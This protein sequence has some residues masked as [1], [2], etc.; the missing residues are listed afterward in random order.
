[1]DAT[2][3]ACVRASLLIL[4]SA[5]ALALGGLLGVRLGHPFLGAAAGYAAS[6]LPAA[7][8]CRDGLAV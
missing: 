7:R 2:L 5:A 8:A 4:A 3:R 6:L 1:M